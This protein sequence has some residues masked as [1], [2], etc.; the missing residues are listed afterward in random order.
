M[1]TTS[2]YLVWNQDQSDF[3][4]NVPVIRF[5]GIP[6]NNTCKAH[7][8]LRDFNASKTKIVE[9]L[10][11]I[12]ANHEKESVRKKAT[13]YMNYLNRQQISND[14]QEILKKLFKELMPLC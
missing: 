8:A 5:N 6:L 9:D 12:S 1:Q 2:R 4:I 3:E 13:D 7:H 14:V 11:N 10:K